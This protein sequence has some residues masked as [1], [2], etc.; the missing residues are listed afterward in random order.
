MVVFLEDARNNWCPSAANR[1]GVPIPSFVGV[2]SPSPDKTYQAIVNSFKKA[3][4]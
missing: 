2:I 1:F 3:K 4:L